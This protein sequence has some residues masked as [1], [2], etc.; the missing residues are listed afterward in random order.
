[1]RN[2]MMSRPV[3]KPEVL[4]FLR[5]QPVPISAQ[6]LKIQQDANTK[7][8]PIIPQET[9]SYLFQL[10][11]QLQPKKILEVGTAIG[12]SSSLFVE[13]THQQAKVTTI[14][15]FET[16]Y[17]HAHENWQRLGYLANIQ[18]LTGDA[19]DILPMLTDHYDLI[20]L[21][22]A[23]AQY[24]K[25][26]PEVLRLLQPNGLLIIDD[27]LQGGS[28][29]DPETTIRHRDKGI[30]RKLNELLTTVYADDTLLAS[31]LPLGDGLLQITKVH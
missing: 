4:N 26:L 30:H 31:L 29:F 1:M 11:A 18:L 23:K 6:L 14:D 9:V 16:M 19:A 12:F 7:L 8:I 15:R 20:F 17:N 2:E 5:Q 27:V 22:A 10:V 28:I 25:F 3:V 21:D 13:A 24:I